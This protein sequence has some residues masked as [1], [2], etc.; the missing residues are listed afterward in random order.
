MLQTNAAPV[1]RSFIRRFRSEILVEWKGIARRTIP[2]AHDLPPVAL[3]DHIPEL[4]DEL[5]DIADEV[6]SE[7]PDA[8]KFETARRHAL[9]RLGE[10]FG[11]AAVVQEMSIL[12]DCMLR[13]WEREHTAG[14]TGDLRALNL[15]IDRA[16]AASVSR[17]AEARERTLAGMDRIASAT[18]EA[19]D[20]DELLRR[21]LDVFTTTTPAVDTAAVLLA[22]GEVL[23]VRAAVGLEGEVEHGF[24][25]AF[26]EGFAGVIAAERRSRALR[27]AYTDD[28]VKS[29]MM[30]KRGV[31]ALY[32]VPL[33]HAGQVIGVAHMGSLSA[34][35]FSLEDRQFFD[36]LIARATV[37]IVHQ[38]LRTELA[39]SRARAE[40]LAGMRER[41]LAKLEALLAA[42]PIGIAFVDRDLRYLRVN[43]A[44]ATL[45]GRPV[46]EH[47][48]RTVG[49]LLPELGGALEKLL[50]EVIDSGQ[51]KLNLEIE[52][53]DAVT[54]AKAWLLANYFPVRGDS[55]IVSGVGG[56]VIDVTDVRRA[57]EAL[58]QEQAL[59]QSIIEHSPAAIWVKNSAGAIV[60]GN[61]Q[62]AGAIG[63]ETSTVIGKRSDEVLPSEIARLHQEHDA[64]VLREN[65]SIEVEESVPSRD[66]PRTFLSI[67]FPIPG[68]PPLVGGIATEITQRKRM[69]EELRDAV[70]M[71]EDLLAI[72]SHDLRNP[73]NTLQLSVSMLLSQVPDQRARRHLELINRSSLRMEHLIDDLLDTASI[74]AGRF[75]VDLKREV[76]SEVLGEAVDL[77]RAA[78]DERGITLVQAGD[79]S[80]LAIK[81]DRLRVLQ[82]FANL[83]GNAIKFCRAG[84]TITV[85]AE[86]EGEHVRFS[87]QDSGP[88]I[89]ADV[90]PHLFEP[91]WSGPKHGTQGAGLGLFIVR[92][93]VEA[94]GGRVSAASPPGSGALFSFTLPIV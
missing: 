37:G 43:E 92:G 86:R 9:E 27:S 6:A 64:L 82:V 20:V 72:V 66:G 40:E 50:R 30:R 89:A 75:Q 55:N 65:R 19:T 85:T 12:R 81:C 93:I 62:L 25:L 87:I 2:V 34:H 33:I 69:E 53:V 84:D 14:S 24:S 23:R 21:L 56:I 5:A 26:G 3:V 29:P 39:S 52:R 70:R 44:L 32:G 47:I 61:Q 42:S 35:E 58:R 1:V 90:L 15:A 57:Q 77:Q 71:R 18:L 63:R 48:G 22:E 17:F 83:V 91:Y 68:D 49:E 51:A 28:L 46:S 59:L 11:V 31:R 10:G 73:L 88:G 80:G 74:R 8:G 79:V 60:L 13:V 67:K 16:I 45:N 4:L 78:A 36:S 94:H 7:H 76:A 41:A 38:M 54:G